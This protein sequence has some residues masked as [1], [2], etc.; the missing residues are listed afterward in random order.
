MSLHRVIALCTE[1]FPDLIC[2]PL[3]AQFMAEEVIALFEFEDTEDGVRIREERHYQLVPQEQLTADEL[4]RYRQTSV[5]G[6]T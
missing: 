6:L 3:A 5:S 2:R 1:K 4:N